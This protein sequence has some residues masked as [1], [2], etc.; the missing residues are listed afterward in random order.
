[1]RRVRFLAIGC[2]A[3]GGVEPVKVDV[4]LTRRYGNSL[5]RVSLLN[6]ALTRLGIESR[7]GFMQAWNVEGIKQDVP[8]FGQAAAAILRI[9]VDG[10]TFY[11]ACDNDYLPFGTLDPDAQGTTA[12][13]LNPAGTGF[14]F[15]RIPEGGPNN[16]VERDIYVQVAADG[17]MNVRDVRRIHGPGQASLRSMKAAKEKEKQNFA[18]QMVKRVHP[19][20]RLAGYALSNLDDLNAPVTLT[21]QYRITDGALKAS[22]QLMAFRNHWISY[23]SRS[24]GLATRTYPLDYYAAE[25]TVNTVV[26]EL[27]EGFQWVPWNRG[28]TWNCGCVSYES[29]MTQHNQTLLFTD[30]FRISRKTYEPVTEYQHFRGC[31]QMMSELSKQWLIIEQKPPS[32]PNGLPGTL[33]PDP[34]G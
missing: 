15:E 28:Y 4:A 22:D 16:R 26:F 12:C 13:F 23:N 5:A 7:V 9:D 33:A 2:P 20:A 8:N 19:R 18:E 6:A 31:L 32:Q 14:T 27:P 25:E 11:T 34:Q 21:L 3:A 10:R 29:T 24:A 30:R 1:M 17:S